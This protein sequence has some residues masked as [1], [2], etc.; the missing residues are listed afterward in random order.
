MTHKE[1]RENFINGYLEKYQSLQKWDCFKEC[2]TIISFLGTKGTNGIFQGVYKVKG[3]VPYKRD[4]LPNNFFVDENKDRSG[5][6]IYKLEKT[7]V[8][9]E[10][11]GRLEIDWG[12]GTANW[13][14][15]GTTDKELIAIYPRRSDIEFESYDKTILSFEQLSEIIR[16]KEKYKEWENKLS[17]VGGVY[18]ICDTKT[19]KLYVGSASSETNGIWG[20]WNDYVHNKHGGNE[21]LKKLIEKDKNYCKYFQFSILEV[22]PL[23]KDVKEIKDNEQAYKDKLCTKVFGYNKN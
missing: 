16:N 12:K 10:F 14:H 18:V 23:K 22:M 2:D 3:K 4:L 20:R 19:G 5:Y 1:V 17:A 9:E 7:E 11:I 6:A 13:L 15:N 21:E 8:L